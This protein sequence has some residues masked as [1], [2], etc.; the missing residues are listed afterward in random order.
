MV[1][2]LSG[3]ARS[4]KDTVAK[5]LIEQF[6]YKRIAFADAIRDAMYELNPIVTGSPRAGHVHLADYVDELGWEEAKNHPEVRRLL[7][8]FGTEVGRK[9]FGENV[10]VEKALGNAE[11]GDKIVVTDVR[12][13]D[14][15]REIKN[16]FGEVWRI[17]RPSIVA[18]NDHISENALDNWVFDEVID[19]SNDLQMLEYRIKEAVSW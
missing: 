13:P 8:V 7:Q 5:I 14:E 9:Y 15:A 3:Y 4:G 12:F 17:D 16:L 18:A 6:G 2:G 11:P 1:I 10:W 19:N